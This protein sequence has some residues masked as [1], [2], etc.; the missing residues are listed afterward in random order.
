MRIAETFFSLQGEGLLAG[1]PSLFIRTSGCNLRCRWCDTKYSSWNPE[2]PE[3]EVEKLLLEAAQCPA[4]HVVITGGEPTVARGIHALCAGLRQM[5]KHIT[6]ETAGTVAPNG[7]A[8]DLASLSPKLAHSTPLE[9]EIEEAWRWRHESRRLKPPILRDW[10][11]NYPYQLKFVVTNRPDVE[12]VQALLASLS[13]PI[14]AHNVLLMPEGMDEATLAAR[15]QAL[16]EVC[17][18]TGFRLCPR[19]H[20]RWFGHTR[21][22]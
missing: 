14:P 10:L 13:H 15:E 8:C 19:L 1:V 20:V 16:I 18:E 3:I 9:G 11:S 6:I 17:R 7:I 2:G 22:T 4:S 12:E 21:G 5:G